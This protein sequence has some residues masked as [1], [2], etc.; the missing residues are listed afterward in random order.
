LQ[1]ATAIVHLPSAIRNFIRNRHLL[2]IRL[3][4]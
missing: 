2:S 3:R 1:V 4:D